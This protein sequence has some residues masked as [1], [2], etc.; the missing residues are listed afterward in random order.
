[1]P[2]P[3]YPLALVL[4]AWPA[5]AVPPDSSSLFQG[6][7]GEG[8]PWPKSGAGITSIPVCFRA[9]GATG[10]AQDGTPYTVN[11]T[12]PRWLAKQ[13]FVKDALVNSWQKW[14]RIVFVGWGPCTGPPYNGWLYIDLIDQDCGGC[15]DSIPRGYHPAGVRVWLM[16]EN[17]DDR[18]LRT[19]VIHEIG[20]ALG[21]HHEMDRPDARSPGGSFTCTD[22]PVEYS[23]GIPL[24]R[25]YDD[26]SVMNYCA[27]RNRNGLSFGD[28]EGS[29][30]LYGVSS[31]G[32]W[33]KAQPALSIIGM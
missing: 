28:I 22:G 19:V 9:P 16:T 2:K 4:L 23:Q 7:S 32:E 21:F 5:G 14:T 31:A 30:S 10:T 8:A 6:G 26:V 18:L 17:P 33:L 1:M 12:Q 11:Y 27:P 15:G 24:T 29:Q 13:E 25:Y 3:A 20:H